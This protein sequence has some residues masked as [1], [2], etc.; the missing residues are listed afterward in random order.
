MEK[1]S[2]FANKT[3]TLWIASINEFKNVKSVC[4]AAMMT[5]INTLIGAFKITIS[6]FLVISFSSLAVAP[7]A[8]FCGP[9]LTATV[10]AIADVLKYLIRPDGPFFPGFTINEFIIGLIY[11]FLFY[12]VSNITWKRC[13]VARILVVLLINMFLTP[14]WLHILYGNPLL[15][16]VGAR[17]VKNI[18][19]LPFDTAL[20]YF[21]VKTTKR[22][23]SNM[24]R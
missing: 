14:L 11:G 17:V 20:L 4:V 6:Q 24:K 21:V 12:K 3:G 1:N 19:L 15:V 7:C 23:M 8:M 5:A 18:V 9:L 16:L 22:I 10:G 2:N 13:L